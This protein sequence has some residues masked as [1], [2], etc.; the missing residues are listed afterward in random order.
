MNIESSALGILNPMP[1]A[2]L[3]RLIATVESLDGPYAR[4][5]DDGDPAALEDL[6]SQVQAALDLIEQLRTR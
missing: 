4:A 5:K 6:L 3:D 1:D 2:A